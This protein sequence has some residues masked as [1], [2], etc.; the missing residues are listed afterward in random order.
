MTIMKV[1][2]KVIG[3]FTYVPT[4]ESGERHVFLATSAK[5]PAG[6]NGA[7]TSGVPL[8]AGVSVANGT[9]GKTGSGVYSIDWDGESTGP[10]VEELLVKLRAE[11]VGEKVW[12]HTQ[13]E[14]NR[15]TGVEAI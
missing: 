9:T 3:P 15:I 2:F 4:E 10:K 11:G 12:Q 14:F 7:A 1:V 13:E 5:Y 8:P 6:T